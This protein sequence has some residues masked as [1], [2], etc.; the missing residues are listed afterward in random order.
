MTPLYFDPAVGF[1]S[2]VAF[3]VFVLRAI[4]LYASRS[5]SRVASLATGICATTLWPV[6]TLPLPQPQEIAA[7]VA[8]AMHVSHVAS[9]SSVL[10]IQIMQSSNQLDAAQSTCGAAPE[11]FNWAAQCGCQ[12]AE[13]PAAPAG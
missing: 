12:I 1:S 2:T 6:T 3:R 9:M 7:S 11:A 10:T 8:N 5:S 13:P 4:K